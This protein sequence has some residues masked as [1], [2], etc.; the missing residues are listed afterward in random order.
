MYVLYT[1][2]YT[3]TCSIYSTHV[4]NLSKLV[5]KEIINTGF[6]GNLKQNIVLLKGDTN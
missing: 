2:V 6:P 1:C 4:Q 3:F 5:I